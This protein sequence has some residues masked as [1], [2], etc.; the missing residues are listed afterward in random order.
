M[1][2]YLYDN[3]DR[4]HPIQLDGWIKMKK[5]KPTTVSALKFFFSALADVMQFVR[6]PDGLHMTQSAVLIDP[7]LYKSVSLWWAVQ[8]TE[9]VW[10]E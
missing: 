3:W 5:Q 9:T 1:I 7:V 8:D 10:V 6:R 2:A 4:L